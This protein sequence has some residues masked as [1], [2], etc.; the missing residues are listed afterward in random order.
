MFSNNQLFKNESEEREF[1][2][3]KAIIVIASIM[4]ACIILTG[5]FSAGLVVGGL[6]I[7]DRNESLTNQITPN[8]STTGSI[9][10]SWTGVAG[11]IQYHVYRSGSTI[12]SASGRS[13]IATVTGTSYMDVLTWNA[14]YHY[15]VVADNG[16]ANSTIS[17]DEAVNVSIPLVAPVLQGIVPAVS[18]TG[19]I[20][21]NWTDVPGTNR[22]LVFRDTSPIS[23]VAGMT[24]IASIIPSE[25]IDSVQQSGSYHYVIVATDF[26]TNSTTSNGANVVVSLP[27]TP[28][29][30]I[31]SEITLLACATGVLIAIVQLSRK[32]RLAIQ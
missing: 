14:E 24:P 31:G 8:P 25:Y 2:M 10:L 6:F 11:A 4:A 20:S 12:T 22:Y 15:V 29:V 5:I 30:G 17:N 1:L 28:G 16:T 7:A 26:D 23:S 32:R 19:V 27:G 18:T 9:D 21:L 3:K 13:P